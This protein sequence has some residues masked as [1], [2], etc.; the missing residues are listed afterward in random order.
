MEAI[1]PPDS[2]EAKSEDQRGWY[3]PW[4]GFVAWLVLFLGGQILGWARWEYTK[5]EMDRNARENEKMREQIKQQG[6]DIS[7]M[8]AILEQQKRK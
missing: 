7:V 3:K 8:R 5:T 1:P 2:P 6:E 4:H